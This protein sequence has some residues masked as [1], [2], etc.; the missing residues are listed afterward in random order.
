MAAQSPPPLPSLRM[1]APVP[2]R[3]H[4][5]AGTMAGGRSVRRGQDGG[6][7]HEAAGGPR[8][9]GFQ[10]FPGRRE[11]PGGT[12]GHHH[13]RHGIHEVRARGGGEAAAAGWRGFG[14]SLG[15][16]S[17]SAGATVLMWRTTS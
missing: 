11:A 7:H 9:P 12:G 13:H 16:R 4:S 10:R 8:P 5:P 3:A 17:L 14:L 15:S 2:S 6:G 1:A